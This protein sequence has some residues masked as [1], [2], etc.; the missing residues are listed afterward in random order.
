MC[1]ITETMPVQKVA[2]KNIFVYKK[3]SRGNYSLHTN[4]KYKKYQVNPSITIKPE[5]E[6]YLPK[7]YIHPIS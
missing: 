1:L 5:L 7:Y 4:Y 3:L 2:E 6:E